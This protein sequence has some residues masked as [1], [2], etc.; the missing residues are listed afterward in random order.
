MVAQQ[1][2]SASGTT[3]SSPHRS[4]SNDPRKLRISSWPRPVWPR[5]LIPPHV[6]DTAENC[7]SEQDGS[8]GESM[9]GD[10]ACLGLFVVIRGLVEELAQQKPKMAFSLRN[11]DCREVA[12][13]LREGKM[14]V[15]GRKSPRLD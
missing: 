7:G 1:G 2:S 13:A 12:R 8:R 4:L 11:N 9:K 15:K 5:S 6:G 14:E 10:E 3:S